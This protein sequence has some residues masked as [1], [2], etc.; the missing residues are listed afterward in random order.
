MGCGASATFGTWP[1]VVWANKNGFDGRCTNGLAV[2]GPCRRRRYSQRRCSNRGEF[3][4]I[5]LQWQTWW[6]RGLF[7][8][9]TTFMDD[10]G[11]STLQVV[12]F[13]CFFLRLHTGEQLVKLARFHAGPCLDVDGPQRQFLASKLSLPHCQALQYSVVRPHR[14]WSECRPNYLRFRPSEPLNNHAESICR[15]PAEYQNEKEEQSEQTNKIHQNPINETLSLYKLLLGVHPSPRGG[16]TAQFAASSKTVLSRAAFGCWVLHSDIS[17]RLLEFLWCLMTLDI[18]VFANF[19]EAWNI[20]KTFCA[21]NGTL[22]GNHERWPLHLAG[23]LF[24]HISPFWC[25]VLAW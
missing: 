16:V 19:C 3:I 6:M 4:W 14:R 18:F 10:S 23:F 13:F 15:G 7:Q 25:E 12:K 20:T 24:H 17:R 9:F 2:T 5:Q 21:R 8:S 22:D 11:F 1:G